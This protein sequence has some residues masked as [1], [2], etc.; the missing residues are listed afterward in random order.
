[1]TQTRAFTIGLKHGRINEESNDYRRISKR[2][3]YSIGFNEGM[4]MFKKKEIKNKPQLFHN[5]MTTHDKKRMTI[6]IKDGVIQDVLREN[7]DC[8]LMIH[9]YDIEGID[10]ENNIHCKKDQE[11]NWYQKVSLE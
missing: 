6:S 3:E 1:M 2:E 9:D 5:S 11:G 10:P 4:K 8:E 7:T